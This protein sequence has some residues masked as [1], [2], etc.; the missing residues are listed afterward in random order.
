MRNREQKRRRWWG[1][2]S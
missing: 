2:P 1:L